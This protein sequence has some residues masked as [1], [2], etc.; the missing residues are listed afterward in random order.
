MSFMQYD[1]K[2]VKK[3]K[4]A[5]CNASVICEACVSSMWERHESNAEKV[6][7]FVIG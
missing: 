3:C 4:G 2:Y 6:F 5:R 7:C 1:Y